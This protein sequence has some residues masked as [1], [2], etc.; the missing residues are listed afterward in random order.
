M[1]RR[2]KDSEN[3]IDVRTGI[4][5][6]YLSDTLTDIGKGTL[7]RD[8][9]LA[10]LYTKINIIHTHIETIIFIM[11]LVEV[12]ESKESQSDRRS[13]FDL[14]MHLLLIYSL[15]LLLT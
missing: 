13:D 4:F 7:A 10:K 2:Q 8:P 15:T 6:P 5:N 3:L 12:V 9:H 11:I 14:L 1:E